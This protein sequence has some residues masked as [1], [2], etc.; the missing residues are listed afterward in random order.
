MTSVHLCLISHPHR[1]EVCLSEV[2]FNLKRLNQIVRIERVS[3]QRV[4]RSG[5]IKSNFKANEFSFIILNSVLSLVQFSCK[6]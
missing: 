2:K 1:T 5:R 6:E 3:K 4:E